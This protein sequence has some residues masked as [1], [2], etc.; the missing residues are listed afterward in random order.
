MKVVVTGATG[1]VGTSVLEALAHYSEVKSILGIARRTPHKPF[2]KTRFIAADITKAPLPALLQGADCV[3][4]LAWQIQP[5]RKPEQ[6]DEVNVNGTRHV[7]EASL[8]A[9]VPHVVFAS[10]VG[11]YSGGPKQSYVDEDWPTDGTPGSLY[12]QQK[13]QVECIADEITRNTPLLV[14][15]MRPALVFKSD[16]AAEIRRLFFGQLVP[17]WAF[18]PRVTPFFPRHERLRFQVVHSKDVGDAFAR[19]V[20]RRAAGPFN[21][22]AHP[23]LDGDVLARVLQCPAVSVPRPLLRGVAAAAYHLRLQPA[24]PSWLDMAMNVPL[25]DTARARL[26]LD[27]EPTHDATTTIRELLE[28]IR[29]GTGGGTAP[30]QP[31]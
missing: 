21:L 20:V 13:V 7:F 23:P 3:V 27:W 6:L 18:D 12:S 4:H 24:S 11:A 10:S 26:E 14:A 28:G 9:G 5:S 31:N 8:D 22:A 30:L 1:N 16:A 15:R 17:R 19:A 2:A 29:T 25:M